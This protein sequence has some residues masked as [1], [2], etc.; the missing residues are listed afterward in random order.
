MGAA[1]HIVFV[2]FYLSIWDVSKA[3]AE[4]SMG[5]ERLQRAV[6]RGRESRKRANCCGRFRVDVLLHVFPAPAGR[7]T[8]SCIF[9]L[10][11][12]DVTKTW[13]TFSSMVLAFTFVFGNSIRTV[14]ER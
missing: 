9:N 10:P 14:Y 12:V 8:C 6:Q 2:L 4:S 1:L 7:L 11:Q 3:L 13:L 5:R